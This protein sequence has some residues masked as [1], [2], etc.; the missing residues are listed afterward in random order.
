MY[1]VDIDAVYAKTK[2]QNS[3]QKKFSEMLILDQHKD[4]KKSFPFKSRRMD[5]VNK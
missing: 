4:V 3:N 1:K 5:Q 2:D